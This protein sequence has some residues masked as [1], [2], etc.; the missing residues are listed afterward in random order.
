MTVNT[1]GSSSKLN[2]SINVR[3]YNLTYSNTIFCMVVGPKGE[4]IV[5]QK[6]D[7]REKNF[8]K[9]VQLPDIFTIEHI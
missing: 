2:I 6:V 8:D 4:Y 3:T 1:F 9:T 5:P 7:V